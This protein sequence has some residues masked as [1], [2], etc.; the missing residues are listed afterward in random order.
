MAASASRIRGSAAT[1][2]AVSSRDPRYAGWTTSDGTVCPSPLSLIGRAAWRS[3]AIVRGGR[4]GSR[5]SI[6]K[7]CCLSSIAA[8]GSVCSGG[9]LR[10]KSLFRQENQPD[11][12]SK[13]Q[14][15]NRS[16]QCI[17]TPTMY[18]GIQQCVWASSNALEPLCDIKTG[19][20][21]WCQGR[22]PC[23]SPQLPSV[24]RYEFRVC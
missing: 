3:C 5:R 23:T 19:V 18:L 21:V 20:L 2:S 1:A 17:G 24:G 15:V 10:R 6:Q 22:Q 16:Q 8:A 7:R 9:V 12:L 11:L 4:P 13:E 14:T